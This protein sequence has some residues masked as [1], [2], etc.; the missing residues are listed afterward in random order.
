MPAPPDLGTLITERLVL[1]PPVM[2]DAAAH[3]SVHSDPATN[4]HNPLG[5]LKR[6]SESDEILAEW[7]ASWERRG[8]GYWS[9]CLREQPF[10]VVGFG[11]LTKKLVAGAHRLNLYFR[12]APWVWGRGI[13][14]EIGLEAIR[15]AVAIPGDNRVFAL[16]RPGNLSSLCVLRKLGMAAEGVLDDIPGEAPSLLFSA[17][18]SRRC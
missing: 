2:E 8:Y 11:G 9:V 6:R 14:T 16:V 18:P 17:Q 10:V 5:P 1:R 15:S 7:I 3:F 12:L 4:L 13:A